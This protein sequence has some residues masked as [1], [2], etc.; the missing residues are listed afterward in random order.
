MSTAFPEEQLFL[1]A[2]AQLI[3][4]VPKAFQRQQSLPGLI[5]LY[6]SIDILAALTR[7]ID[8]ADT[9]SDQFKNWV[10]TYLLPGSSLNCSEDELW[11]ARCGVLHTLSDKTKLTRAAKVWRVC[12]VN[13]EALVKVLQA[14][15]DAQNLCTR[16]VCYPDLV[17]AFLTAVSRFVTKVESDTVLKKCVMHHLVNASL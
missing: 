17:T 14:K 7:P 4:A 15:C 3:S 5:L 10:R 1:S 16:I 6:A 11:S 8:Q 2:T 9:T 12:Y 13:K